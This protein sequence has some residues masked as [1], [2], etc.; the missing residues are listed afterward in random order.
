MSKVRVLTLTALPIL[1]LLTG[2]ALGA[3][4]GCQSFRIEGGSILVEGDN[5][6]LKSGSLASL[7]AEIS[8]GEIVVIDFPK[9]EIC[10]VAQGDP[11]ITE[12]ALIV[13]TE[14]DELAIAASIDGSYDI[15]LRLDLSFK[16]EL[17]IE[18]L[19]GEDI[20]LTDMEFLS[21]NSGVGAEDF[22]AEEIGFLEVGGTYL[23]G[24]F[25]EMPRY[26]I[27]YDHYEGIDNAGLDDANT[28]RGSLG[29]AV[30]SDMVLILD[31]QGRGFAVNKP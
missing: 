17:L 27:S 26:G 19:I 14:I 12:S 15:L 11:K 7:G 21:D 5:S 28:T 20:G 24:L 18:R 31:Y 8:R 30:L 1:F 6:I 29:L 9:S 16:S 23:D 10:V 25:A 2:N 13:S 4:N 22:F 3:E